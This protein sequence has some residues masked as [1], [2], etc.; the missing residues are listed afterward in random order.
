VCRRPQ[1]DQPAAVKDTRKG[2]NLAS[3]WGLQPHCH[4]STTSALAGVLLCYL[5]AQQQRCW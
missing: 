5:C 3:S 2:N 4:I 1:L